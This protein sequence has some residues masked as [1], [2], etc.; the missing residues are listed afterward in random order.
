MLDPIH[1]DGVPPIDAN[2]GK[3]FTVTTVAALVALHPLLFVTVNV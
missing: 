1:T 2:V 3:V